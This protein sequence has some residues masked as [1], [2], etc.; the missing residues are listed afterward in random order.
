[1]DKSASK[2]ARPPLSLVLL[3]FFVFLVVLLAQ[4]PASL[5]QRPLRAVSGLEVVQLGGT[6]WNGQLWANW[7][8]APAEVRW[9]LRPERLLL[10]ELAMDVRADSAP[11]MLR[12]RMLVGPSGPAV[13]GL[14]GHVQLESLSTSL[15]SGSG[16]LGLKDFSWQQG[17]QRKP[18]PRNASGT[19]EYPGGLVH[20]AL[21]GRPQELRLPAMV[22]RLK[23]DGDGGVALLA[24]NAEGR[25]L[26]RG[27][28]GRDG[29]LHYELTE[30]LLRTSKEYRGSGADPDA[31]VISSHQ[32]IKG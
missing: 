10:A 4:M 32:K 12:G 22:A 29:I 21:E 3:V 26:A 2:S 9:R 5:L 7:R 11:L 23:G 20:M 1:M 15:V 16:R 8:G 25:L 13:S 30:R 17:W 27:R 14:T 31:I 6:V 28:Y 18:A 19:L 24:E